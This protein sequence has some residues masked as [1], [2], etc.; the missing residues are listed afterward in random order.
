MTVA[1][2]R[3]HSSPPHTPHRRLADRLAQHVLDLELAAIRAPGLR[4]R[5]AY[6]IARRTRRACAELLGDPRIRAD[7]A[8]A[9]L[10]M[11]LSHDLPVILAAHPEYGFNLGR[12]AKVVAQK[13]P[14]GVVID[15]GA[16]VGDSV[17]II[18]ASAELRVL[19][20]EAHPAY[21]E[22]LRT[23][24]G[25]WPGVSVETVIVG[26]DSVIDGLDLIAEGGTAGLIPKRSHRRIGRAAG[27]RLPSHE[28][29]PQILARH[30]TFDQRTH[31]VKI[32]T[33]GYDPRII[34]GAADWLASARPV[35]FFEHDP[36]LTE[37]AGD[38]ALDVFGVL[39]SSGYQQAMIWENSGRYLFSIDLAWRDTL[40]DLAG[41][42][43][44]QP[45]RYCDVA[46]FH[47]DDSDLAAELR[48]IER[49]VSASP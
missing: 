36:D 3:S 7:V 9:S 2:R 8:G 39:R 19:C 49:N 41:F 27:A 26:S 5:I 12:V 18:R 33:D 35:L 16:N 28:S 43:A 38:G 42:Y 20:L 29:L 17:A 14:E 30:P 6:A 15:I 40:T 22:L 11:N 13:Y 48:A 25:S 45:G 1:V 37:R 31:L 23:N 10:L 24:V 44:G 47:A 4:G 34:A 21:A 46:A 32:D